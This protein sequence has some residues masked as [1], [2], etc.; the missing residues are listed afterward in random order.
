MKP[1]KMLYDDGQ[2]Y[3]GTITGFEIEK[4]ENVWKYIITFSDGEST[5]ACKDDPV[6]EFPSIQ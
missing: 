4:D 6:V 5:F 2:W 1:C 3:E